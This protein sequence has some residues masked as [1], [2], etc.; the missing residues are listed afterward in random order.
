[1]K[2]S[3][4]KS[5]NTSPFMTRKS[6]GKSGIKP[7]G[8]LGLLLEAG[9][10]AVRARLQ[11]AIVYGLLAR[12]GGYREKHLQRPDLFIAKA[13]D[14]LQPGPTLRKDWSYCRFSTPLASRTT[15]RAAPCR[16]ID[17]AILLVPDGKDHHV[18]A[19]CSGQ[20]AMQRHVQ[21]RIDER[22]RE[23]DGRP[24]I[25]KHAGQRER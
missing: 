12:R 4:A 25:G 22:I 15:G 11:H 18:E 10:I 9:E 24:F 1:M 21:L 7:I 5:V 3:E 2:Q 16:K 23:C 14:D 8:D 13:K 17:G 20:I 19:M 6:S